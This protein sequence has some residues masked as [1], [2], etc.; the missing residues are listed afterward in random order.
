[1]EAPLGDEIHRSAEQPPQFRL[2]IL[3]LPTQRCPGSQLV[4]QVDVALFVAVASRHR[5]EDLESRDAVAPAQLIEPLHIDFEPGDHHRPQPTTSPEFEAA[6][7]TPIDCVGRAPRPGPPLSAAL[8]GGEVARRRSEKEPC[9]RCVRELRDQLSRYLS[10][11]R[12]GEEI[13]I[14]SRGRAVARLVPVDP[15]RPLDRLIAEGLVSP[16]QVA[17]DPRT[18]RPIQARGIESDLVAE[19]RR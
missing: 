3:D 12:E 14:T 17:K 16:R 13:T 2:E 18:L 19:Q 8:A 7:Q 5:T 6:D 11:V 10:L 9:S 4:Q 15:P 1:M